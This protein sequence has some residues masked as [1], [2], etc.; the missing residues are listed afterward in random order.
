LAAL[1]LSHDTDASTSIERQRESVEA[2][3]LAHQHQLVHVAEDTDVSGAV[4]P[5]DRPGLGQ[6][7]A[8]P[9]LARWD[10]LVVAKLDRVSRSLI[11]FAD[12]LEWLQARGKS[13]VSVAESLDF[14]TPTGQFVGKILILFAEF[15][16]SM[17]RERRADA[18]KKLY[19][20]GGYNGGGSLPWGYRPMH[21]NGRIE[22]EPDPDLVATIAEVAESVIAGES[23]QQAAARLGLDH[24]GLLRRLRSPSLKGNV[25]FKGQLVR[26]GDG[27]PLLREPVL[28]WATWSRLQVRL[29]MNSKGAGVP[30][31]AYP[32]LH[33]IVCRKCG[34]NLYFQRWSKRPSYSYLNHKPSLKKYKGEDAK[35]RCRFSCRAAD[36]EPQIGPMLLGAL[37]DKFI[38]EVVEIPGDDNSAEL[39]QAEES[40]VE[41]ERDRYERGL[42]RGEAGS[43]RYTAMMTKLEARAEYLRA[44][45]AVPARRELVYPTMT[46]G[47]MWNGLETDHERGALLRRMGMKVQVFR[48]GERRTRIQVKQV[49]VQRPDR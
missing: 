13:L 48:D 25:V 32:W 12:L 18:A 40:I 26:G 31:D 2:W 7:M 16:R 43:A 29:D 4:A 34:E 27:T 20:A 30:R 14:S 8:G 37:G 22:L 36:V 3:A 17:M 42:F 6:W 39:E 28:Q 49:R 46:F 24:A 35:E 11:D 10:I 38:P 9:K 21:R 41:L 23:V 15:E 5:R 45:P 1:R 44:Q 19:S 33:V 47:E